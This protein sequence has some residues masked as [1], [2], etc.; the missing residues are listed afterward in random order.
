MKLV[1]LAVQFH[2][3][4]SHAVHMNRVH[5][6]WVTAAVNQHS[7][8]CSMN[9]LQMHPAL[10]MNRLH[11]MPVTAAVNVQ[12]NCSSMNPLQMH[13]ALHMNRLHRMPV[14]A[15]VNVQV[16]CSS[17]NPIHNNSEAS[18]EPASKG[19]PSR[20]CEPHGRS[21]FFAAASEAGVRRYS[22]P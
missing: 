1:T 15:A 13:P 18:L 10:H 11:R 8:S 21:R 7:N 14:T 16:N 3:C 12:V 22:E 4:T 20:C 19:T 2:E 9:P 5:T 6:M 17:Y